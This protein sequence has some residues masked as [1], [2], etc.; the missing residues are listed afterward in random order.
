MSEA[1]TTYDSLGFYL[2]DPPGL[3]GARA[4]LEHW[5]LEPVI[6]P[7][8]PSIVIEQLGSGCGEGEA[9]IVATGADELKFRAPGEE[10]LGAA[11]EVLAN[12]SAVLPGATA[13]QWV[14]VYRDGTYNAADLSGDLRFR[15]VKGVNNAIGMANET[16]S[17]G[18]RYGC[19]WIHNRSAEAISDIEVSATGD[20]TV[21]LE[22]PTAGYTPIAADD[23]TAPS[24][25]TFAASDGAASLAAGESLLLR[26]KRELSAPAVNAFAEGEITVEWV[27]DAVTYTETLAGLYG[28]SDATLAG[29]ALFVGEDAAPDLEAAPAEFGALPLST[30]LAPGH[31]HRWLVR[32]VNEY[33][34]SSLNTLSRAVTLDGDGEEVGAPLTNPEVISITSGPGGEVDVRLRYNGALDPTP[35][36]YFRLYVGANVAINGGD[37]TPDPETDEAQDTAIAVIGLAR[38]DVEQIVRLGP[39]GYGVPV[40]VIARVYSSELDAES[41][42]TEA[43][44]VT[45]TTQGPVGMHQFAVA[46]GGLRGAGRSLMEGAVYYDAP[47]NSVGIRTLSGE[48]V[49]FGSDEAFRAAY[50]SE[51]LF[52]TR[53]AVQTVAHSAAGAATPIEAISADEVYLN[54][55]GV[56]RAK[57]DFVAGTIEAASFTLGAARIALPVIGPVYVT[58]TET[59]IMVRNSLTGRWTPALRVND[60]GHLTVYLPY[61]QEL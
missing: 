48:V 7:G 2:S 57:I 29:Y 40:A 5:I 16:V 12:T 1:R 43:H 49:F 4:D 6:E 35:A 47:T 25:V 52:R 20:Y 60:A 22:A 42:S 26:W 39:Y 45:V 31:T 51:T 36:D 24:G 28:V 17:G 27:S 38:P 53:F 14:R 30:A 19:L 21:A 55:A 32:R 8:I 34:L 41:D 9:Y 56:R 13:G 11:V 10:D 44:T 54:V 3:G 61:K 15:I 59:N 33:G 58:G 23:E 37:P 46:A 18:T 50:G